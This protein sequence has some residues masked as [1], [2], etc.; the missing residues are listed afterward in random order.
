M[1]SSDSQADPEPPI[2][3][4]RHI[5]KR[6]R[7]HYFH[8]LNLVDFSPTNP[9]A[10]SGSDEGRAKSRRVAF[11]FLQRHTSRVSRRVCDRR[12]QTN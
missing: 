12:L 9:V 3:P 10:D 4:Q 2:E 7:L 1:K 5:V 11:C 8:Q 6:I